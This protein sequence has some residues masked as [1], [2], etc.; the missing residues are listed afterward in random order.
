MRFGG[1]K[2]RAYHLTYD[3]PVLNRK[4]L[5]LKRSL[6]EV[7]KLLGGVPGNKK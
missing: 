6:D 1:M 3:K 4:A 5:Q 7:K 2:K